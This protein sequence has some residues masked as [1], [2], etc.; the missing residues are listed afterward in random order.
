MSGVQYSADWRSAAV[1]FCVMA[2]TCASTWCGFAA[3][4]NLIPNADMRDM[5]GLHPRGWP[6]GFGVRVEG[7]PD[8]RVL[9]AERANSGITFQIPVEPAWRILR[10][11]C[12]AKPEDVT[13]GAQDWQ[14]GRITM[15]YFGENDGMVPGAHNLPFLGTSDWREVKEDYILP[16]GVK[17]LR[18]GFNNLGASGSMSYRNI[19]LTKVRDWCDSSCSA[20]LPEGA[21]SDPES[22]EDAYRLVSATRVRYSLNGLWRCRPAFVDDADDFIP[23]ENEPWS[24]GRLPYAWQEGRKVF[25]AARFASPYLED[26]P[27][28]EKRLAPDRVWYHRRITVPE[29][30]AGRRVSVAFDLIS[31]KVV[32][33]ANGKRAGEAVFPCGEVD[34]TPFAEP[35]RQM[36]LDLDV[37]AYAQ[38]AGTLDF[39][40]PDRAEVRKS[41]VRNKGLTGDVW[42]DFAPQK[43]RIV[44]AAV[45][46]DVSS[47]TVAVVGET[48]GMPPA[49]HLVQA[50]MRGVNDQSTKIIKGKVRVGKDGAFRLTDAWPEAKLWDIHTPQNLYTCQIAI[51]DKRGNVI[52]E[53]VPFK[54]GYR[55]IRLVGREI[56]L[57][58]K[59]VHLRSTFL[60]TPRWGADYSCRGHNREWA[61]NV[62]ARGW[63]FAITGNYGFSPGDVCSFDYLDAFDEAGF[64]SSFSLPHMVQFDRRLDDPEVASQYREW[65]T[66]LIRLV[67]NHPSLVMYAMNHNAAGY[68]GDQD[69]R[70]IGLAEEPVFEGRENRANPWDPV[71]NRRIAKISREIVRG[72]DP[73]RP[74]Y[75]H[76]SGNLDDFH[77]LNIYLNWAPVQ[78]RSDWLEDW[79][80][81]GAKPVFFVEWGL[82]H[83]ASWSSCRGPAFIWSGVDYQSAWMSE[84]GAIFYGDQ[85]YVPD[86][87]AEALM[88]REEELWNAG[89]PFAYGA[90]CGLIKRQ[91]RLYSGV[92][93][94]FAADNLRSFRAWGASAI[95][96]WDYDTLYYMAGTPVSR[97]NPAAWIG[98]KQ[99]GIVPDVIREA[100]LDPDHWAETRAGEAVKRWFQDDCAWIAGAMD[101]S[102]TDKRHI[103]REGEKI[104]KTLIIVNDRREVQ[105]VRWVCRVAGMDGRTLKGHVK[106]APGGSMRIPVEFA[107]VPSGNHR[108]VAAFGFNDGVRQTDSFEFRVM[109]DSAPKLPKVQLYDP[110]GLTAVN[111]KRIGVAYDIVA[112]LST[113]GNGKIVIGRESLT[114]ELFESKLKPF[115]RKGGEALVFEQSKK[116]L[117]EIGFRVQEYGL[118]NVFPLFKTSML[119]D[120][121]A[122]DLRDWAGEST[123]LP[124][125]LPETD[126]RI[127]QGGSTWAGFANSRVWRCRNRGTV[128][129]VLPEIPSFGDWRVLMAGSFDMQSAPL[130]EWRFGDGALTFCQLD[131]TGRTEPEPAADG[132]VIRLLSRRFARPPKRKSF[133]VESGAKLSAEELAAVRAGASALCLGF[134]AEEVKSLVPSAAIE[135]VKG[136]WYTRV[137]KLPRELNGLSNADWAWHGSMDFAAFTDS[138]ESG[139]NLFRVIPFGKGRLVFWQVP[140]SKIDKEKRPYLRTSK[141]HAMCML[142]RLKANLGLEDDVDTVSYADEPRQTDDPFRYY[143]W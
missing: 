133:L 51:L 114:K 92:Q 73:S 60:G 64:L 97:V 67:R 50:T 118:R 8:A 5:N 128:A 132:I 14:T 136:S 63:N 31:T 111:L 32:V 3:P 66:K 75:H 6:T 65:C 116:T 39:N 134:S 85:A 58:G 74:A 21:V 120:V 70:Q 108:L 24:W 96:P 126:G 142:A 88:R 45:E 61:R 53:T 55:E 69:P 123:L 23:G 11:S 46:A 138:C 35:G 54:F 30:A 52:D 93:G 40:A 78:E 1:A 89:K 18:I 48:T 84:Y 26:V 131:V 76:E 135:D 44:G 100:W 98:A 141:R 37:T 115:V 77:T 33:Y 99:P 80:K 36:C 104:A 41:K 57:N 34:I 110:R 94:M 105:Q 129:S 143:R 19:S 82:P 59:P 42:L 122:E 140:P 109:A 56:L 101:H 119:S 68:N 17:F 72:I 25:P 29:S 113:I 9:V 106:V 90:L 22:I 12:E 49:E 13:R 28:I 43:G 107:A 2:I 15:E 95:L 27:D 7:E 79:S 121:D 103:Y 127:T 137:D 10:L 102:P 62:M 117:E 130:L 139:N 87:M 4:V 38:Q 81:R 86:E 83:L 112:D 91:S 124:P 47:H 125:Y 20:A 16:K 71:L